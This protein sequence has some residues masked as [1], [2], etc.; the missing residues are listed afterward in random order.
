MNVPDYVPPLWV[1]M[2]EIRRVQDHLGRA[3]AAEI[4]SSF[5]VDPDRLR[6]TLRRLSRDDDA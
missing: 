5:E 2:E 6:E 3:F 1:W 4:P